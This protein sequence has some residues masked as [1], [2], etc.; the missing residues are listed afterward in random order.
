M[1]WEDIDGT[2][3]SW[4]DDSER[5]ECQRSSEENEARRMSAHAMVTLNEFREMKL[6]TDATISLD[7]GS[8]YHAHRAILSASSSYFRS[9]FTS[10]VH[11][12]SVT[13]AHLPEV[14][15]ICMQGIL[16]YVYLRSLTLTP[17]NVCQILITA[18]YLCIDGAQQLCCDYLK[19]H[20]TPENCI[21]IMLFSR[22]YFCH[23]LE[24]VAFSFILRNYVRVALNSE[25]LLSLSLEDFSLIVG[26][27][28]LNAKS[29]ET[30]WR[31]V[32]RWV[33]ADEKNRRNCIDALLRHIRLGLLDTQYLLEKVKHLIIKGTIS[34]RP[35]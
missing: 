30:V 8:T 4:L 5:S 14:T 13:R 35:L 2:S 22:A 25:E 29:E 19:E 16:E 32:L 9:L 10:T 6:L 7:D 12:V 24:N 21:G 26:H 11:S 1:E 27:D 28:L 34:M 33:A 18:D 17:L 31:S 20:M 23:E 15:P 3:E